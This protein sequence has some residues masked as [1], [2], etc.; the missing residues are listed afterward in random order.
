MGVGRG[1]G[2]EKALYVEFVGAKRWVTSVWLV[3]TDFA[4][5]LVIGGQRRITDSLSAALHHLPLLH[6]SILT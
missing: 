4:T 2:E 6:P 5:S 1:D 3:M